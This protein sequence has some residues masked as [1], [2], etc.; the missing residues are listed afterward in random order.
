MRKHAKKCWGDEAIELAGVSKN[1]EEVEKK[2]V[3]PI[4]RNGS[5]QEAF[6]VV[7]KGKPVYSHRQLTREETRASI[8]WWVTKNKWPFNIVDDEE[9]RFLMKTGRPSSYLPSRTTVTRDTRVVFLA[10]WTRLSRMLRVSHCTL[11]MKCI[12]TI[13]EEI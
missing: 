6:D 5:I 8:V 11:I 2:I 12:L 3:K 4:L 13:V 1:R 7:G 9:F 10:V